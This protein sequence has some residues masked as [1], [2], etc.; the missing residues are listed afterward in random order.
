L[1]L[2]DDLPNFLNT[3]DTLAT[4][5][6]ALDE[7]DGLFDVQ[8]NSKLVV[9]YLINFIWFLVAQSFSISFHNVLFLYL[10]SY[11]LWRL[12]FLSCLLFL[13]FLAGFFLLLFT[14]SIDFFLKDNIKF[15][16]IFSV[17]EVAWDRNLNDRGVVLQVEEKLV[18]MHVERPIP[19]VVFRQH[20]FD[21]AN[22]KHGALH[23]SLD[24]I[25]LLRMDHLVVT[26]L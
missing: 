11:F 9:D 23:H 13:L 26:V 20:V 6:I 22:S 21:F 19:R 10:Q 14:T 15:D 16:I 24:V 5:L 18:Q 1:V 12:F 4:T 25:S 17:L 3:L 8:V 7:F 2:L